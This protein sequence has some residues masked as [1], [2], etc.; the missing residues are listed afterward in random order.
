MT[1]ACLVMFLNNDYNQRNIFARRPKKNQ[2]LMYNSLWFTYLL[3]IA[4][5]RLFSLLFL[6]H[7]RIQEL[8]F[9]YYYQKSLSDNYK[10]NIA[11]FAIS[12][13]HA[14]I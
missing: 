12:H 2:S 13:K 8:M 4:V 10:L 14:N 7:C 6:N 9:F 11:V 1:C 3:S 5:D